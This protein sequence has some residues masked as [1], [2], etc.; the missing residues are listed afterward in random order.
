[1]V[2]IHKMNSCSC[3][4]SN[5]YLMHW[6]HST[7]CGSRLSKAAFHQNRS[8]RSVQGGLGWVLGDTIGFKIREQ[9]IYVF[10]WVDLDHNPRQ[11]V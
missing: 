7:L 9:E 2:K 4:F 8:Y 1:M 6:E 10:F 3:I 5:D 11:D